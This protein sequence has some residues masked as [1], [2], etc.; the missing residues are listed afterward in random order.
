M[1]S[2]F[3]GQNKWNPLPSDR[4]KDPPKSPKKLAM[5]VQ[6]YL[7]INK[8]GALLLPTVYTDFTGLHDAVHAYLHQVPRIEGKMVLENSDGEAVPLSIKTLA[9]ALRSSMGEPILIWY[10]PNTLKTQPGDYIMIRPTL[11]HLTAKLQIRK[12]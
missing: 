5:D 10:Q 12:P 2:N 7:G 6:G 3:R 9:S 11:V 4:E 8:L 1:P